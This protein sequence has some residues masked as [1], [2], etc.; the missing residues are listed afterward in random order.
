M[1]KEVNSMDLGK[2]VSLLKN[3]NHLTTETLARLSGVPKGTI[4]K[5]L[6]GETQNPTARTL[7]Q[8]ARALGCTPGDLCAAEAPPR[9]REVREPDL[10]PSL[11]PVYPY[12]VPVFGEPAGSA[13]VSFPAPADAVAFCDFAFLVRE[14]TVPDSRVLPGDYL[15]VRRQEDVE[16]GQLALLRQGDAPFVARVFHLENNAILALKKDAAPVLYSGS[17]RAQVE[18]LGQVIAFQSTL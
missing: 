8:L 9:V 13:P 17:R 3:Q 7:S 1:R 14:D 10:P 5:I 4:N 12:R 2:R 6:N 16:D 15:F 11:S 18:I